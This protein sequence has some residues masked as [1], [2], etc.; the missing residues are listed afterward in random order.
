LLVHRLWDTPW[1]SQSDERAAAATLLSA[2][3]TEL[4]TD[5]R[6]VIILRFL[7]DFSLKET[8]EI[9]GKNTNNVK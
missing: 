7:E 1:Q 6:L 8:A 2:M 5:Q 4:S 9:I 3:N